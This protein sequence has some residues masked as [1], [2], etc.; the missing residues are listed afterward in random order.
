MLFFSS[1]KLALKHRR[2]P[3]VTAP[4]KWI[5]LTE[6]SSKALQP[7]NPPEPGPSAQAAHNEDRDMDEDAQ[8]DDGSTEYT[9]SEGSRSP[10]YSP[11]P[12][13][14]PTIPRPTPWF[15]RPY[16]DT[17]EPPLPPLR[18]DVSAHARKF[19]RELMRSPVK[20]P[21]QEIFVRE[22]K[23]LG[24]QQQWNRTLNAARAFAATG[25]N[26]EE[27][28]QERQRR[29]RDKAAAAARAAAERELKRQKMMARK[30][31]P[32]RPLDILQG[33]AYV[34]PS[35]R[36]H[37]AQEAAGG[38]GGA[39]TSAGAGP[40]RPRTA[41]GQPEPQPSPP[42]RPRIPYVDPKPLMRARLSDLHRNV[43]VGFR[44]SPRK[45]K[46]TTRN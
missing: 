2:F 27:R 19:E 11:P 16:E 18:F 15:E 39:G 23:R 41:F 33:G 34:L 9:S 26:L 30:L 14:Q 13:R 1:R 43:V 4:L 37:R 44:R 17:P 40:S 20:N 12:P 28:G 6:E 31:P 8:S 29:A 38:A 21:Q 46:R 32:Q 42:R 25:I 45:A 36:A 3:L 35:V 10:S 7:P 5:G 24:Q 22:L